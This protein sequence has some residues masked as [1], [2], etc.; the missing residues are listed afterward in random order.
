M[1]NGDHIMGLFKDTIE[2]NTITFNPGWDQN[3]KETTDFTDVRE[4][5]EK[6]KSQGI[7]LDKEADPSTKG[8]AHI[9]LTDP[10]G[11][12]ILIDQFV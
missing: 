5:Q 3:A 8:P 7:K 2:K 9:T 11:N 4:I 6:L 1:K 10:D 12:A